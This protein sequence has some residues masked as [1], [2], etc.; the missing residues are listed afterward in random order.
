MMHKMQIHFLPWHKNASCNRGAAPR[1]VSPLWWM[2]INR[3]SPSLYLSSGPSA[4]S[5]EESTSI[6]A[7]SVCNSTPSAPWSIPDNI[8]QMGHLWKKTVLPDD[9]SLDAASLQNARMTPGHEY[10]WKTYEY[11]QANY[12]GS[13]WHHHMALVWAILF[14]RVTPFLFFEKPQTFKAN[15]DKQSITNAIQRMPWTKAKSSNHK[16]VSSP[17]PYVTML[18]TTI[19]A[20]RD[21]NSPLAKHARSHGNSLGPAWTNK[22]GMFIS[23][24]A[25]SV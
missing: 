25:L 21:F 5:V 19:F 6:A 3:N 7:T 23:S 20:L 8:S 12:D 9:W 2:L 13:I 10:V 11:V 15:T 18:S 16:G 17:L 22:H 4:L 1:S 14:S 24:Y